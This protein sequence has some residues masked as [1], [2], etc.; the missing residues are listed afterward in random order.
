MRHE[1]YPPT[2]IVTGMS[3]LLL[4]PM[5]LFPEAWFGDGVITRAAVTSASASPRKRS[6]SVPA[7]QVCPS[8]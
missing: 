7:G 3:A 2:L 5:S 6:S 4:Y 8:C 1:N